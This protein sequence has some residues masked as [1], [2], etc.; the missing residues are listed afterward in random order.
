[1]AERV[2]L[3]RLRRFLDDSP[4]LPLDITNMIEDVFFGKHRGAMVE[5]ES[6]RKLWLDMDRLINLCNQNESYRKQYEDKL[7]YTEWL[8]KQCQIR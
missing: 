6:G 7:K 8:E 3:D 2:D 5:T 1:M 4:E